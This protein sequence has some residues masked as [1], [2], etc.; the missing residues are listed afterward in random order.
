MKS[1]EAMSSDGGLVVTGY[2]V[3]ETVTVWRTALAA[4]FGSPTPISGDVLT[5]NAARAAGKLP[6]PPAT[7]THGD[8]AAGAW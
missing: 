5:V 6:E 3:D 4:T 2:G 7:I 8:F 1:P